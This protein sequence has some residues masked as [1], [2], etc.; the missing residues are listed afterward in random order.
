MQNGLTLHLEN[1]AKDESFFVK[2][3]ISDGLKT[4]M[5][6]SKYYGP[7]GKFNCKSYIYPE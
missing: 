4:T 5:N 2:T 1:I 6:L 7:S 3:A